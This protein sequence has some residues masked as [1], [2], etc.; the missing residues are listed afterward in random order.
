MLEILLSKPNEIGCGHCLKKSANLCVSRKYGFYFI[1][2]RQ[3]NCRELDDLL[4]AIETVYWTRQSSVKRRIKRKLSFSRRKTSKSLP[5]SNKSE[6]SSMEAVG[7]VGYCVDGHTHIPLT[8]SV[9]LSFPGP[10]VAASTFLGITMLPTAISKWP[11][12]V[13]KVSERMIRTSETLAVKQI[14]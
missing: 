2:I 14:L 6:W 11:G 1:I 5:W 7:A 10:I 9:R 8:Q 3:N 4:H 13:W 12:Y